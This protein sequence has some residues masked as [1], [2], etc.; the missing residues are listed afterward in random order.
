[1]DVHFF[2]RHW[3]LLLLR[4]RGVFMYPTDTSHL[5]G[6]IRCAYDAAPMAYI[7]E[8]AGGMAVDELVRRLLDVVPLGPHMRTGVILGSRRD[9]TMCNGYGV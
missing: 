6:K 5:E 2:S 7:C 1:M 9:V 4:V 8:R 3:L